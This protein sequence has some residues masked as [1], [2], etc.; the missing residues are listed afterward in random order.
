MEFNSILQ[1]PVIWD[2]LLIKLIIIIIKRLKI[3]GINFKFKD[4]IL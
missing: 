3:M 2:V 4:G 1:D